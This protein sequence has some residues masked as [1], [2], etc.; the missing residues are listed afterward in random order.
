MSLKHKIL[1]IDTS[2]LFYRLV[3]SMPDLSTS[4][5]DAQTHILFGFVKDV[6]ALAKKFNTNK[7]IF[8]FDTKESKRKQMFPSY[9]M[10]RNSKKQE[11]TKEEIESFKEAFRQFN[12]LQHEILPDLGFKNCFVDPGFESDDIVADI[13]FAYSEDCEFVLISKDEDFYQLLDHCSMYNIKTQ[14]FYTKQDLL[15]EYGII[16]E[17][18]AIALAHSGCSTDEIPGV[19]GVGVKT[20]CKYLLGQLKSTSK[21]YQDI[22]SEEG[23]KIYE[24]NLPLVKLPLEGTKEF[25]IDFTEKFKLSSFIE[26]CEEMK[27]RSLLRNDSINIW[28]TIFVKDNK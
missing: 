17:Q 23:K 5:E 8:C 24:R 3:F 16:P 9:K 19:E 2:S 13:V 14:E 1:I 22:V 7:F 21:K 11:R 15:N 25:E 20:A 28:S 4:E 6:L 27:F 12:L 18:Y 26:L 10:K